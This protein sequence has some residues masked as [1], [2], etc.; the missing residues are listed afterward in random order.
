[1]TNEEKLQILTNIF[2]AIAEKG[3]EKVSLLE[4]SQNCNM[5]FSEFYQIFDAKIQ[6]PKILFQLIDEEIIETIEFDD[7]DQS[8]YDILFD[9]FITRF[10]LLEPFKDGIKS[11]FN[12]LAFNPFLLLSGTKTLIKS[13]KLYLNLLNIDE[14]K[15]LKI[16]PKLLWMHYLTTKTWLEDN[17]DNLE[18]TM[19]E[20]DNQIKNLN[21]DP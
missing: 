21:I 9:V 3:W 4:I 15:K 18:K 14:A 16:I 8:K 10:E 17:S 7:K 13:F 12:N 5:K 20:I 1:M 2:E 6:I 19:V 11:I